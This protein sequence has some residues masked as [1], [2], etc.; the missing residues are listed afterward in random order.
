M[1]GQQDFVSMAS[2]EFR[3]PLTVIDEQ[4]QRLVKISDRAPAGEIVDRA[5]QVRRAVLQMTTMI[6]YLLNSSRLID[7]GAQLYFHP[8][9]VDLRT[10]LQEVC[11]LHREIAPRSPITQR[12]GTANTATL[13]VFGDSKLLFQMFS[14]LI[15]N[16]VKYS[17]DGCPIDVTAD[18]DS[19]QIIVVVQ[20]HGI[21]IPQKDLLPRRHKRC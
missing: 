6:D 2:H 19:Q 9:E 21:G 15:S 10:L 1:G 5:K 12:L 14:N 13:P 20:D 7:H 16:A 11:V 8:D 18:I 4:A 17:D 3:T